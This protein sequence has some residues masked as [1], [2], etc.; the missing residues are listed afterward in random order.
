MNNIC[1]QTRPPP[2]ELQ[3]VKE[4]VCRVW[5]L[6][7]QNCTVL[8]RTEP[9][10]VELHLKWLIV[11]VRIGIS[12]VSSVDC[13]PKM[14]IILLLSKSFRCWSSRHIPFPS[15]SLQSNHMMKDVSIVSKIWRCGE[16]SS[17][18]GTEACRG[19]REGG[20]HHISTRQCHKR[21]PYIYLNSG[22]YLQKGNLL[23]ILERE[24]ES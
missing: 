19:G 16:L 18:H 2:D 24:R 4:S 10:P 1:D 7:M 5:P 12:V 23:S 20:H 11:S 17:T 15:H 13:L 6:T 9:I 3:F 14:K 21:S 22:A 8:H